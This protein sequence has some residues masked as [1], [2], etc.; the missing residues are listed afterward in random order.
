MAQKTAYM[1]DEKGNL[2]PTTKTVEQRID[3]EREGVDI[4]SQYSFDL[5]NV[6]GCSRS[7]RTISV[8]PLPLAAHSAAGQ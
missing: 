5:F 4:L 7:K 2:R 3:R 1:Q 8:H 6:I